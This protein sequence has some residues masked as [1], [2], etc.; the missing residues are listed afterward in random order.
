LYGLIVRGEKLN[1]AELSA[2]PVKPEKAIALAQK[3]AALRRDLPLSI[4]ERVAPIRFKAYQLR[5]LSPVPPALRRPHSAIWRYSLQIENVLDDLK[6]VV[7]QKGN[8]AD[9]KAR[10]VRSLQAAKGF[11]AQ[12]EREMGLYLDA[13]SAARQAQASR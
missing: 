10:I 4:A 11:A 1:G 5:R 3:R 12:A 9:S 13:K 2:E 8:H 6:L 7:Y